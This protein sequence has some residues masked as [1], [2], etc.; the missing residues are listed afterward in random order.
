MIPPMISDPHL[1]WTIVD[2][3]HEAVFVLNSN[4]DIVYANNAFFKILKV[5]SKDLLNKN[6]SVLKDRVDTN[7]L[8]KIVSKSIV[9]KKSFTYH[10]F[11]LRTEKNSH[12]FHADIHYIPSDSNEKFSIIIL[13]NPK[14]SEMDS[15]YTC[16]NADPRIPYENKTDDKKTNYTSEDNSFLL[17]TLFDIL[18]VHVMVT[19]ERNHFRRISRFMQDEFALS[20]TDSDESDLFQKLQISVPGS[21]A[22][23]PSTDLPLTKSVSTGQVIKNFEIQIKSNET[24][25]IFSISAAPGKNYGNE[26]TG[27]IE[28]GR[29]LQNKSF[30]KRSNLMQ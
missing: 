16:E 28:S 19:D 25:K 20:L 3:I 1:P 7:Y 29:I 30:N 23:I 4:L 27:A 6:L 17:D 12:I 26:I 15:D 14:T 10:D 5:T 21:N 11:H 2:L 9:E 13:I 24:V 8:H 22:S 18:P